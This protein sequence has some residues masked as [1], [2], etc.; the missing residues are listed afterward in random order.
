MPAQT[1]GSFLLMGARFSPAEQ[2]G[3]VLL[4]LG[5]DDAKHLLA[6]ADAQE[7]LHLQNKVASMPNM[8][9]P[10]LMPRSFF[11]RRTRSPR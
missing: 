11:T 2:T 10:L 6:L 5:L 4:I 1:S 9:L 7:F 3:V 8:V